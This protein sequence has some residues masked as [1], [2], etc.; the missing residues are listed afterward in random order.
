M[1]PIPTNFGFNPASAFTPSP[2]PHS[3]QAVPNTNIP[4]PAPVQAPVAPP[5]PVVDQATPQ[6]ALPQAAVAPPP[7]ADQA[8]P[9]TAPLRGPTI[10]LPPPVTDQATPQAA[11][12]PALVQAIVALPPPIADQVTPQAAPLLGPV[13][14]T[15][16]PPPLL[17]GP[18]VP[19]HDVIQPMPDIA[20]T[21]SE[22]NGNRSRRDI[23]CK[24]V[25]ISR[26]TTDSFSR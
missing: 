1:T 21:V 10:V 6:A 25:C 24:F 5:P 22:G 18:V 12:L 9:Q 11:P 16:A 19:A 20:R 17:A 8:T 23:V 3:S 14:P 7:V 26:Y 4:L 15:V 2:T 13:Q